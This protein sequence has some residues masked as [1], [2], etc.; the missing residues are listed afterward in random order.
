MNIKEKYKIDFFF[1]FGDSFK[2]IFSKYFDSE[3]IILGSFRNN[4]TNVNKSKK[5][6]LVYISGF[7][8]IIKKKKILL[9][10]DDSIFGEDYYYKSDSILFK[11]LLKYCEKNKINLRILLRSQNH[12]QLELSKEKYFFS[13][14]LKNNEKVKFINKKEE[15]SAYR[16][17]NKFNYFVT[18][19]STLGYEILSK[20][21]RVAFINIRDKIAKI[22]SFGRHRFGWPNSYPVNKFFWTHSLDKKNMVKCLNFIYTCK[23][24]VWKKRVSHYGNPI[25]VFNSDNQIFKKKMKEIGGKL[26]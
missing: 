5:K 24:K 9:Q 10:N 12:N 7:K 11:F 23:E 20:G 17:I 21:K 8:S 3:F 18:Q 4:L 22:L 25:I 15:F 1:V 6:D 16:L 14:F 19:D 13:K 26:V 2:K